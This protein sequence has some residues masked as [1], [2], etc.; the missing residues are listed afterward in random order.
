M[1][2][3]NQII[4]GDVLENLKDLPDESVDL[5]IT[6]P[7]YYGLRRYG[8]YEQQIGL[9]ETFNEYLVKIMEIMAELKRI[10]KSMG[11]F[12][13]NLGDCYGASTGTGSDQSNPGK[14][15]API[16]KRLT[17]W[18]GNMEKSILTN[19]ER[20]QEMGRAGNDKCLLMMPERIALKM[21]GE[22]GWILRNK[23]KWAKQILDFKEKKTK[24]SVMP[25]SVKDRFNESGEELY[26]FVKNKKY[27]AD[28]DAVRLP[29]QT[30]DDYIR[31]RDK[32]KLNNTPGRSRMG[33]LKTDNFNYRV[34]DAVRKGGQPQFKAS[35][36]EIKNYKQTP[37]DYG[38]KK[39]IGIDDKKLGN[40]WMSGTSNY[41]HKQNKVND[42][43][44]NHAGGPG[45][46][47]DFKDSNP[48]NS[49]EFGKNLPTVWLIGSEPH[50]FQKELGVA[51]DHF[52]IFPR[53]LCEIPIKF[54]CPPEGIVLDPFMG[55]GTT[56]VVARSLG[57]KYLGIELNP[58]YIKIAE[59]RLAQELLF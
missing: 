14:Q 21:I 54:G 6:S 38:K 57:R 58:A 11:Q 4:C 46:W 48:N 5:I 19:P 59:K 3:E 31:N 34:P 23:I 45:S 36:E 50:N 9:E 49:N 42:P 24:G 18:G 10:L 25:S 28:L 35:E 33:G 40:R 30:C 41:T 7:P 22:Q 2:I 17:Y 53:A 55:S 51:I 52:A 47:R 43:R 32:S 16:P 26:F 8:D 1:K 20:Q 27:Y 29:P 39:L 37:R 12:L 44:G 13:L 56:A 15:T